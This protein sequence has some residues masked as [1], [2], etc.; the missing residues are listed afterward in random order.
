[1]YAK[2]IRLY[3]LGILLALVGCSWL[4]L[5]PPDDLKPIECGTTALGE[6]WNEAD[7]TWTPARQVFICKESTPGIWNMTWCWFPLDFDID[8]ARATCR[9]L[10]GWDR[11]TTPGGDDPRPPDDSTKN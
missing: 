11:R 4:V 7:S 1:M 2:M 9:V 5:D 3:S 6:A 8:H 10:H